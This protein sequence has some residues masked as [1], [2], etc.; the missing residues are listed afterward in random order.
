[1]ES[2]SRNEVT[3]RRRNTDSSRQGSKVFLS[4]TALWARAL[5]FL[6]KTSKTRFGDHTV[7]QVVGMHTVRVNHPGRHS[8]GLEDIGVEHVTFLRQVPHGGIEPHERLQAALIEWRILIEG[9]HVVGIHQHHQGAA[10]LL[11]VQHD[12][13]EVL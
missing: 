10:A 2:W 1:M 7:P 6:A 4:S 12:M 11:D 9:R 3:H 8:L 13:P 5:Q